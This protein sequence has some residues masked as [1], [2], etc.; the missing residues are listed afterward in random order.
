MAL[1][2]EDGTGSVSGAESYISVSDADDYVGKWHGTST[3][4]ADASNTDKEI[5]LRLGARYVDS[6]EFRGYRTYED[7]PLAWPRVE[8]GVVDGQLFDSD[9]IPQR[10]ESAQVEAALRHVQGES[11]FPD[12]DGGS[13][14][15]ES[16]GVGPLSES[17]TY[18]TSKKPQKVFS[19][20]KS[21]L[22]PLMVRAGQLSRSIG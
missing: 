4:W 7:Q 21:L 12:H 3:D 8:L 17:T 5:A 10:V 15:S 16:T 19:V 11:L 9:E 22:E 1:I 2:I 18:M 13:V 14:K 20:V 6:H